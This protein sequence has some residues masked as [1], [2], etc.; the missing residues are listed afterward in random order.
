MTGCH[1]EVDI[2]ILRMRDE[3]EKHVEKEREQDRKG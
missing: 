1:R 3:I 2:N